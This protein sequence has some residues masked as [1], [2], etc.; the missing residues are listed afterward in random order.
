MSKRLYERNARV[1]VMLRSDGSW[2]GEQENGS[3]KEPNSSWSV[4]DN[5]SRSQPA[6]D[7]DPWNGNKGGIST[8]HV[9]N[10]FNEESAEEERSS[11]DIKSSI[12]RVA[13]NAS[14]PSGED[15]NSHSKAPSS[16]TAS[17]NV[18][19]SSSSQRLTRKRRKIPAFNPSKALIFRHDSVS[20]QQRQSWLET[21]SESYLV[22]L[23]E[24]QLRYQLWNEARVTLTQCTKSHPRHPKAWLRLAWLEKIRGNTEA[25]KQVY[26]DALRVIPA[27]RSLIQNYADLLKSL[28]ELED[29]CK[30][31][32]LGLRLRKFSDQNLLQRLAV[33]SASM[34][35]ISRARALFQHSLCI[36][37]GHVPTVMSW[38]TMEKEQCNNLGRARA[39]FAT[40]SKFCEHS[41]QFWYSWAEME[42]STGDVAAV[43][44][45]YKQGSLVLPKSVLLWQAWGEL[46]YRYGNKDEARSYFQK[47]F[48]C[49]FSRTAAFKGKMAPTANNKANLPTPVKDETRKVATVTK[50]S[51]K[52]GGAP[53]QKSYWSDVPLPVASSRSSSPNVVMSAKGS[54]ISTPIG[55]TLGTYLPD[56][57]SSKLATAEQSPSAA[58]TLAGSRSSKPLITISDR[59]GRKLYRL[60]NDEEFQR[61]RMWFTWAERELS[62][63]NIKGCLEVYALASEYFI[64]QDVYLILI[65]WADLL[66][67]QGELYGAQEKLGRAHKHCKMPPTMM[68][69]VMSR[70]AK[71]EHALGQTSKAKQL[72]LDILEQHDPNDRHIMKQLAKL[73]VEDGELLHGREL[74]RKCVSVD[75]TD[76]HSLAILGDIEFQLGNIE[77]ARKLLAAALMVDSSQ[78]PAWQ[79]FVYEMWI[80]HEER[81]DNQNFVKKLRA[82]VPEVEE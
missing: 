40:A 38:A 82:R 26:D 25:A 2:S 61:M 43:R 36:D 53:V 35:K 64:E 5:L 6:L 18:G 63:G 52:T 12:R 67:E 76:A 75:A 47:A 73:Y 14:V 28:G 19:S 11:E 42:L 34:G 29:A 13:A 78:E 57:P 60:R 65:A 48:D 22:E 71:V 69:E 32:E 51:L 17:N 58:S 39:L 1:F 7:M 31:Y 46:E 45:L 44:A 41:P 49:D 80:K 68:V 24:H 54:F 56:S 9:R 37:A 16:P 70:L 77:A 72:C 20:E 55:P 62:A 21:A 59:S 79:R 74:L 10:E 8:G 81:F 30:I 50:T 4:N 15:S 27:S 66:F 33:L 3:K 23:A